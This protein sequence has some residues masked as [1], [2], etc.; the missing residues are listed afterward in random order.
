VAPPFLR[1]GKAR[2][3]N[4]IKQ[5]QMGDPRVLLEEE[6]PRIESVIAQSGQ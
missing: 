6:V 2:C 3:L 1:S 5:K 4:L